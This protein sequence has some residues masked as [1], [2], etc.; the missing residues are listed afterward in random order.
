MR[1][2]PY[3]PILRRFGCPLTVMQSAGLGWSP[4]IELGPGCRTRSEP[5][6]GHVL[7]ALPR[8]RGSSHAYM[9]LPALSFHRS[10]QVWTSWQSSGEFYWPIEDLASLAFIPLAGL[11]SC[12]SLFTVV[13]YVSMVLVPRILRS[14]PTFSSSVC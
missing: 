8:R 9:R 1:P 6:N 12:L 4:A 3:S 5:A 10:R 13:A 7:E 11:P 14:N 2:R